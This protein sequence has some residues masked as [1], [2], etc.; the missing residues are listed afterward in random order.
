M[1]ALAGLLMAGA[2][3]AVDISHIPG[4]FVDVGYG[5]RPMAMGGAY[6]GIADDV[7]A[8]L[9][10]PA[11][12]PRLQGRQATFMIADQ[13]G[14]VPTNY[15]AYAQPYGE[16]DGWALAAVTAGDEVLHE[17]TLIG[18]WGRTLAGIGSPLSSWSFGASARLRRASFGDNSDPSPGHVSGDAL[19]YSVDA[20]VLRELGRGFRLGGLVRDAANDLTWSSS[21]SGEYSERVPTTWQAGLGFQDE[22][23]LVVAFDV[24]S[25][26]HRDTHEK[27]HLGGEYRLDPALLFRGGFA[28][29]IAADPRRQYSAGV[30]IHL[31]FVS[32]REVHVDGSFLT[33]EIGDTLRLGGTFVF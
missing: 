24:S 28:Q 30:G 7:H 29:F 32:G 19:G 11:G 16:R 2:A 17:F 10:N 21:A 20:G 14:V 23:P 31:L 1:G 4:A 9:W 33:D 12:L 25:G 6:A 22:G 15:A 8:V 26:F 27:L 5:P 18:A 3:A 13:Y